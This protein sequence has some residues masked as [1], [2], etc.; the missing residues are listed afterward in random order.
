[1]GAS[2]CDTAA[3][4]GLGHVLEL[5]HRTLGNKNQNPANPCG[6]L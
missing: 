4:F 3:F 2:N 1:M 5:S 6:Q